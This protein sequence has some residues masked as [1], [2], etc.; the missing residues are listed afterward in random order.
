MSSPRRIPTVALALA[1]IPGAAALAATYGP[2]FP[3][4]I[5]DAPLSIAQAD[6]SV[7]P[8]APAPLEN[9]KPAARTVTFDDSPRA[10]TPVASTVATQSNDRSS[11][12]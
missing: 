6:L 1:L 9:E 4:A 12:R 3:P 8:T 5:S 7:L 2:E 11:M 10:A